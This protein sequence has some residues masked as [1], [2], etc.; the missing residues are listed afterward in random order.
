MRVFFINPGLLEAASKRGGGIEEIDLQVGLELS[1][2]MEVRIVSTF[3]NTEPYHFEKEIKKGLVIEQMP[4][5]A[6]R[7]YPVTTRADTIQTQVMTPLFAGLCFLRVISIRKTEDAVCVVHNGLSG[8]AAS[9]ACRMRGIRTIFSEGNTIPW[10]DPSIALAKKKRF[11]QGIQERLFG[12]YGLMIATNSDLIRAQSK[13]IKEGIIEHGI[14]DSEIVII[15]AGVNTRDYAPIQGPKEE[16][17]VTFGFLGRLVDEKGAGFLLKVVH[18]MEA[19]HPEIKFMILGDGPYRGQLDECPNV[20]RIGH[21]K[22]DD[23][24]SLFHQIDAFLFFQKEIGLGELETMS[25]GK[26]ILTID[27]LEN[28]A[29]IQNGVN[30]F[31]CEAALESYMECIGSLL[32]RRSEWGEIGGKARDTILERY[33]WAIVAQEWKRMID[34]I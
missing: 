29:L 3:L 9:I 20:V 24:N 14:R 5:L 17:R 31:L 13:A 28:S 1:E 2:D 25:A 19:L 32:G 15:P 8:L 23:L 11:F 7:S 21:A 12:F 27:T 34:S 22:R 26:V 18:E 16:N 30:G 33:S 10:I 4:L 6:S